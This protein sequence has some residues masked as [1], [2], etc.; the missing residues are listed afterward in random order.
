MSTGY[1]LSIGQSGED[2]LTRL[3]NRSF[4]MEQTQRE[5]DIKLLITEG[6]QQ[7]HAQ[8]FAAQ[9]TKTATG[10]AWNATARYVQ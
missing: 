6:K 1:A 7:L 9:T 5:K 8:V 10:R 4:V 3:R 2:A